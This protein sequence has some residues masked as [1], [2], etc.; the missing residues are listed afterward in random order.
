MKEEEDDEDFDVP[1]WVLTPLAMFAFLP[2]IGF[3]HFELWVVD[4][5]QA[6]GGSRWECWLDYFGTWPGLI[7]FGGG[8]F[9]LL[10]IAG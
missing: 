1:W 7:L 8:L 6:L 3:V 2:E 9:G 4:D 5:C 10:A